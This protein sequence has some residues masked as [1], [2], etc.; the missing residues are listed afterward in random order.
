MR[1][2]IGSMT[3]GD[4][5][6]RGVRL[7]IARLPLLFGIN[8]IVMIPVF[9]FSILQ[10]FLLKS[11]VESAQSGR[12]P[13]AAFGALLGGAGG[14]T[15]L[16]MLVLPIAVAATLTVT[17]REYLGQT[18]SVGDALGTAFRRFPALLGTGFI[19]WLL[20]L[21]GFM[22]CCIPGIYVSVIYLF[23][24]QVVI[25]ESTAGMTAL[26]RSNSLVSGHWWRIFAVNA[27]IFLISAVVQAMVLFPLGM[28]LPAQETVMTQSGPT[29]IFNTHN[30][31]IHALVQIPFQVA[32]QAFHAVCTTLLYLDMRI[33]KEGLDLQIAA[34]QMGQGGTEAQ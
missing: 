33:R 18:V 22:A 12:S 26:N 32:F 29:F 4:V 27:L 25:A 19:V 5:L 24:S 30:Q 20:T 3:V 34:Q 14:A 17:I 7:F 6:D 23:A 9:A 1:F 31:I 28:L 15:L 13:V 16:Y 8:F 21:L 10:P 2:P 11:L